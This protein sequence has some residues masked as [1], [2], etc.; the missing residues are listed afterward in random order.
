[1]TH[2]NIVMQQPLSDTAK[3]EQGI[4]KDPKMWPIRGLSAR[5]WCELTYPS[6]AQEEQHSRMGRLSASSNDL[7][8]RGLTITTSL[9]LYERGPTV[10]CLRREEKSA[11]WLR[12]PAIMS[13][14]EREI[15]DILIDITGDSRVR[16]SST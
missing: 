16:S 7:T 13:A 1:M 12:P 6:I 8:T 9:A 2:S 14:A 10:R 5:E 11:S 15:T 3:L 4:S